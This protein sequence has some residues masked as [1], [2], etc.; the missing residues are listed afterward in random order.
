LT[1][2]LLPRQAL[3]LERGPSL[4]ESSL[5]LLELGLLLLARG[6]LLTELL[7]RRGERSSL[8]RQGRVQPLSLLEGRVV[9]LELGAGSDT[10]ASHVAA[11]ECAP[12]RS[13]R[14]LRNA[15]SR[16]TSTVLTVSTTEAPPAAWAPYC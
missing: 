6:P 7:L 8:V 9:P 10:S 12:A 15:S 5:L 11:T 4:G 3:L 14:A 16:S 1:Q 2:R 13:S